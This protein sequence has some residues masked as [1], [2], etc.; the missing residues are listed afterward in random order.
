[1][2]TATESAVSWNAATRLLAI[3]GKKPGAYRVTEIGV[4]GGR[5]FQLAKVAGGSDAEETGYSC[6]ITTAQFFYS[7]CDCKG[8]T[9]FG[10]C[11]HVTALKR[12]LNDGTL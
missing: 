5:G 4:E 2:A 11:R 1:M 12:L 10:Y 3:G 7:S 8:F 6:F 9:R